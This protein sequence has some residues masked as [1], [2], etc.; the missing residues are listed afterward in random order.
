MI[1]T[2]WP[3]LTA[4]CF[5]GKLIKEEKKSNSDAGCE[6]N[7]NG[8]KIR[9]SQ[10]ITDHWGCYFASLYKPSCNEKFDE[11]FKTYVSDKVEEYNSDSS[12]LSGEHFCPLNKDEVILAVKQSK[13]GKSCG[14]DGIFY[15]HLKYR[16]D[17]VTALLSYLYTAVLQYS[18][19]PVQMKLGLII[20]LH[21]GN[22]KRKDDPDN[23][24]AITLSSTLLKLYER[25]LLNRIESMF[26]LDDLGGFQKQ[27]GCLFTSFLLRE[28][29]AFA[30]ENNSKLYVCFFR[31]L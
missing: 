1:L 25:I 23:Y 29:V 11:N 5:G 28:S 13:T 12:V 20:T 6:I 9:G 31:S 14:Y 3:K 19:T 27:R 21:K 24:R 18:H 17:Y 22:R 26:T 15:E 30:K 7:F 4:I 8:N 2:T 10:N 16:G